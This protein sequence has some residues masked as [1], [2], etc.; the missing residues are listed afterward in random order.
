MPGLSLIVNKNRIKK[1]EDELKTI[2]SSQN[3]LSGYKSEIFLSNNEL[4]IGWNKYEQYP[5]TVFTYDRYSIIIEGEIYNK[6]EF[7]LKKELTE[8]IGV[9]DEKKILS[10]LPKWLLSTDG[11]FIIYIIDRKLNEV[12]IFNDV[13]G[14]LPLYYKKNENGAVIISRYLNFINSIDETTSLDRIAVAQ[15]LLLGYMI[16]KR[17]LLNETNQFRPASFLKI[18]KHSFEE[19][20]VYQFNFDDKS[21]AGEKF[22]DNVR[23]LSDLFG[24]ACIDRFNGDEKNIVTLSGGLDS[25]AVASCMYKNKIPFTAATMQYKNGSSA[26]EEKIALELSE[27]YNVQCNIID[28]GLPKGDDVYTLLKIK[29]GMN[30]LATSQMLPFYDGIKGQF[31]DDINFITGDNGDKIIFT[32]NEQIKK[33]SNLRELAEYIITQHSIIDVDTVSSLTNVHKEEFINEFINVLSQ[34]PEE[35]L[36]Q[37]YVHFR[38]I[39]KPHKYAFQGEDRHRHFFINKTP[40]WSVSFFDYIM[41]CSDRSKIKHKLFGG[42]LNSFSPEATAIPYSNFRASINSLKGKAFM[43]AVYNLSHYLPGGLK[44]GLKAGF[45]GGNPLINPEDTVLNLLKAQYSNPGLSDF[46]KIE[47]FDSLRKFRKIVLFN[48]ITMF[49]AIELFNNKS[50]S[51]EKFGNSEF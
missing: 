35:D 12:Y 20:I 47:D 18:G 40:F 22:R 37:K 31:G 11:D 25:R 46:I 50:I 14:R 41:K 36:L 9:I 16:N 38:S 15:F 1:N 4:F 27:I 45:F 10:F 17:T 28:I 13:F 24:K 51:L 8:I 42:L 49:S 2:L 3:Y 44:G 26:E 23:N 6:S 5:V 29:E 21:Y 39:E 19:N 34:L 48:I 32:F 33:F 30:S 43:F 7:I